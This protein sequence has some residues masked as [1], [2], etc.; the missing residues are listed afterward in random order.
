MTADIENVLKVP[1]REIPVPRS[2]S[3]E[4]QAYLARP[5]MPAFPYPALHDVEA[6]HTMIATIEEMSSARLKESGKV[7][8]VGFEVDEISVGGVT[9]FVV[10]P[11]DVR[12]E[13]ARVYLEPHGGAFYIGRGELCA[14]SAS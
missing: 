4:A 14:R 7:S 5:P 8:D 2:V 6:W 13:D 12:G 11:P 3:P 10:T 9:V 1:A